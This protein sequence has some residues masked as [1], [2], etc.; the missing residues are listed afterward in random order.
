MTPGLSSALRLNTVNRYPQ[1]IEYPTY[2]LEFYTF[3]GSS[4]LLEWNTEFKFS[5]GRSKY[6]NLRLDKDDLTKISREHAHLCCE[7]IPT[8]ESFEL[9]LVDTSGMCIDLCLFLSG[10]NVI[11]IE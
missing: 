2:N 1:D 3:V 9:F 7:Y 5:V 6:R 8:T 4:V 11:N 10:S